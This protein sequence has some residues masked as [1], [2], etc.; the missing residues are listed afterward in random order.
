M[1]ITRRRRN[2]EVR[3][4]VGKAPSTIEHQHVQANVQVEYTAEAM[5]ERHHTGLSVTPT[6]TDTADNIAD[7]ARVTTASTA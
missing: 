2:L 4:S 1:R 3:A 6:P 7:N 5:D